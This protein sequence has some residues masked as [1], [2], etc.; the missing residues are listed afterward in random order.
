[1]GTASAEVSPATAA[2]AE[3]LAKA[4]APPD[5]LPAN[6][7]HT[8]RSHATTVSAEPSTATA[9]TLQKLSKAQTPPDL[10]PANAIRPESQPAAFAVAPEPLPEANVSPVSAETADTPPNRLPAV[11]V[12]V[13]PSSNA[14][15]PTGVTSVETVPARQTAPTRTKSKITLHVDNLDVRKALEMISR[16]GKVNIL[17]SPRVSGSVTM[18]IRD[19]PLDEALQFIAKLCHLDVRQE[20]DAFYV[21]TPEEL[22]SAEEDNMPVRVYHLNFIKSG[23]VVKMIQ[24]LLSKKGVVTQSPDSEMGISSDISDISSSGSSGNSQKIQAGGNSWAGGE[25]LVVKDYEQN[26]KTVDRVIAEFDVEPIQVL[27]EAVIVEVTLTKDMEFGINFAALDGANKVLGV[28]NDGSVINSAA[29]FVPATVVAKG[30]LTPGFAEDT[31]G[32]KFGWAQGNTTAFIKALE[33]AGETKVLATPRIMVLNKQRA[34]VH[35]GKNIGYQ[36]QT[37]TQTSTSAT[38]NFLKVGTQLRLRP[39][40][41]NNGMIRMEV[42]PERSDGDLDSHQIPQTTVQQVTSNVMIPD[43]KTIIIGGLLTDEVEHDW[44]G[45]PL[46]SRLPYLG[47]L[48][49]HTVDTTKKEELVII[50]TP[51]IIR[52]DAPDAMNYLGAPSTLGLDKHV[53]QRPRAEARDGASLFELVKSPDC[54]QVGP[55][56]PSTPPDPAAAKDAAE[57]DR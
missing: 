32:L 57:S 9:S 45:L 26:L 43:G 27:I 30:L 42:H 7:V 21:S 4:P 41:T 16:E 48:F 3:A 15:V 33:G 44:E 8:D 56:M 11:K 24:P 47:F 17:V 54:P 14:V 1:M 23:E 28:I 36:N 39:F 50:L 5:L 46:V 34:E 10:R 20:E 12:P 22:R 37:T 13:E 6:V 53:G 18:D 2:S 52:K 25:I 40:V 49:R 55:P 38:T 51:H 29:G 31:N 35:L 19:K